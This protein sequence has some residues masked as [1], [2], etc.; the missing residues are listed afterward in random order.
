MTT[1][2]DPQLAISVDNLQ[3][4]Y[5]GPAVLKDLSLQLP[6]GSRCILVGCNGV[7]KSS[8]LRILAG[9][10]MVK[11]PVLVLGQDAYHRTP[12]GITYLGPDWASNPVVRTDVS[13]QALLKSMEADKCPERRDR[14]VELLDI[15]MDWHMHRVSDGERRRVQ[16]L[17]GLLQ[18]FRCLLLDE[19]TVDLDVV[20]RRDLLDYLR[21][22]C[23]DSTILY[24]THIF[25]GLG[26]WPTHVA[27][28]HC[29]TITKVYSYA[30]LITAYPD[31][32]QQEA[33]ADAQL[34]QRRRFDSP[35][36]I[37]VERWLRADFQEAKRH[38]KLVEQGGTHWQNLSEDAKRY[39]DKY[40]NYYNKNY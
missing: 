17:L 40:Y 14:L 12:A 6:S 31:V 15:D 20:V 37:V 7:G 34:V 11:S 38:K 16:L 29:G 1:S 5:G 39:G 8:L 32:F 36:L 4:S 33:S 24:A 30:D 18:P 22:E 19:V 26:E 28:M 9:K 21:H 25:D 13:V 35:L 3:F 23:A 27:H 2:E 10:R